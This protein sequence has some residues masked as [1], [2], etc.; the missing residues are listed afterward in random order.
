MFLI[1]AVYGALKLLLLDWWFLNQRIHAKMS[2]DGI[3]SCVSAKRM[4][5]CCFFFAP[6]RFLNIYHENH[7]N[8]VGYQM[9]KS[10][11]HNFDI[12]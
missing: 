8:G 2:P 4:D 11:V 12:F 6:V 7:V 9:W 10:R 5:F 1:L 3:T